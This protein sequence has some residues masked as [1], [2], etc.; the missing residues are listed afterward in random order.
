MS[1]EFITYKEKKYPIKVGYYALKHAGKELSVDGKAMDMDKLLSGEMENY[2]PLLFHAL[3]MGHR[4]EGRV[5][6]L[7]RE[8]MEYM[9]DECLFKFITVLPNFFPKT[10]EVGKQGT[11]QKAVVKTA[12]KVI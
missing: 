5:M 12:N 8:D 10:D 4:L 9:L 2:E 3:V 11:P 7:K 6:E 1:V